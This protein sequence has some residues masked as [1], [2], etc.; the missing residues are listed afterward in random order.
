[1][2]SL[3]DDNENET[4]ENDMISNVLPSNYEMNAQQE[5]QVDINWLSRNDVNVVQSDNIDIAA[6]DENMNS[7]NLRHSSSG[8][9][10]QEERTL[11]N[12]PLILPDERSHTVELDPFEAVGNDKYVDQSHKN[13]TLMTDQTNNQRR[14]KL[15]T[16]PLLPKHALQHRTRRELIAAQLPIPHH[17]QEGVEDEMYHGH[18][19]HRRR[20]MYPM[21]H[22]N[23]VD[24]VDAR[25]GQQ[26]RVQEEEDSNNNS[27]EE[28]EEEGSDEEEFTN[29]ETGS[30][31]QGYG[32]HYVD[33]W[34]GT[35][36]QRQTVIV[37]TGSSITAFPCSGCEHCGDNPATGEQ[38]HTDLE[39]NTDASDTYEEKECKRGSLAGQQHKADPGIPCDLGSC[40][41]MA[42]SGLNKCQ[43]AVA[44]AEGSSWT[45]LEGSDVVYPAGPHDRALQSK[46][47]MVEA[48]VGLGMEDV[49]DENEFDWMDFRLKFGCQ[50]KV[51]LFG[52]LIYISF[53]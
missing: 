4:N 30:L 42:N 12:E 24:I 3:L 22:E 1:M 52:V 40:T 39:F 19:A 49:T 20:R 44:Y 8:H 51:R 10:N 43:L 17:L 34:V 48:G 15:H 6:V 50:S 29:Y 33:I 36:P 28:E 37:D 41:I 18:N 45:A 11:L 53:G 23:G 26:R 13:N 35:P 16:L 25:G 2:N 7:M 47:E 38:Y 31:Y 27:N 5:E 32:T 9:N 46:E 14:R 21:L